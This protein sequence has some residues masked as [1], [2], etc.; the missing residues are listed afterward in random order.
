MGTRLRAVPTTT[1]AT[2]NAL[3]VVGTAPH[4]CVWLVGADFAAPLPTLQN[5]FSV[6]L[7]CLY[8]LPA[9][10]LS[11]SSSL[12]A[13]HYSLLAT[14][15]L[16]SLFS[17][18]PDEERA[19]RRRRSDACEGTRIARHD[20]RADASSIAQARAKPALRSLRTA[21]EPRAAIDLRKPGKPGLCVPHI[22]QARHAVEASCVPSDG[23]LAFRRSTWGFRPGP[24]LAVVS[25]PPIPWR[26]RGIPSG[27]VRRSPHGSS[28]PGGAGLANLPGAAANR[29]RGRHSLAPPCRIASRS[30]PQERG[31]VG[32]MYDY[33]MCQVSNA[34]RS[35]NIQ[36]IN[37]NRRIAATAS[38]SQ[39]GF[40]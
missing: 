9:I 32:Y 3:P 25:R 26:R 12:F 20:R 5:H 35:E 11:N 34:N 31:W 38:G 21:G 19:E 14:R 39:R 24:V 8:L 18:T 36:A 16:L 13:T 2:R 6:R 15:F 37:A 4:P 17:P 10:R 30:A 29:L 22:G 27:I 7:F 33:V 28:L 1:G 40:L 23:T